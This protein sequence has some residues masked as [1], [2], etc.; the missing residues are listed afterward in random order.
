M[1]PVKPP[2]PASAV[3]EKIKRDWLFAGRDNEKEKVPSARP[4][5]SE[6]STAKGSNSPVPCPEIAQ[7]EMLRS[8]MDGCRSK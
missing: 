5:F 4:Q 3:V 1:S 7:R 6:S 8:S 2:T